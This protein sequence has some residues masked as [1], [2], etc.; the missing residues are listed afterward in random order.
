MLKEHTSGRGLEGSPHRRRHR[1]RASARGGENPDGAPVLHPS[2]R[3]ASTFSLGLLTLAIGYAVVT[4]GGDRP[5]DT[6]LVLLLVGL[7]GIVDSFS[8]AAGRPLSPGD[9]LIALAALL[10]PAYVAFQLVPLPIGFLRVAAP[11]RAEIASALGHV[12]AAPRFAPLSIGPPSTWFYLARVAGYTLTFL[13]VWRIARQSTDR[14]WAPAVP[15]IVIGALEA[16]G[17]FAQQSAMFGQQSDTAATFSGTYFNK[18]HFAGLLA[19]ILPFPLM[20]G[21]A[22]VTRGKRRGSDTPF[23]ALSGLLL[24]ALACAMFAA[25]NLSLSKAG[26]LSVLGSLFVIGALALGKRLS[27]WHRWSLLAGLALLV[28]F[29]FVFLTPTRLVEQFSVIVT[30]DATEG[31]LPIWKDTVRLIAAYPLFGVGMGNFYPGLLRYQTA[32]LSFTWTAAHNDYLQLL[33]ELGVVGW[34]IPAVL[35][36]IV[37]H[38][39]ARAALAGAIR[40][41]SLL[42]LACAGS[43]A[44]IVLHS[45]ADFNM[46]VL[47]NAMVLSWIAGLAAALPSGRHAERDG[48]I[49]ASSGAYTGIR[50]HTSTAEHAEHAESSNEPSFPASSAS[51]AVVLIQRRH[52]TGLR[53]ATRT[54]GCA[55][56]LLAGAWLVFLHGA[57][58]NPSLERLF[59][60]IGLCETV[61]T[62]V[63]QSEDGPPS[64]ATLA[65]LRERLERDPA[66]PSRWDDLGQALQKAGDIDAARYCFTRTLALGPNS[67]PVLLAAADFHFGVGETQTAL[68][69]MSR[70]LQ[71]DGKF[72]AA[73]FGDLDDR[74]I[75][76]DEILGGVSPDDRASRVYLRRLTTADRLAD[77]ET[78]WS[79]M[80]PRG[81]V[82]DRLARDYIDFLMSKGA[83]EAAAHAWARYAGRRSAGY[84]DANRIFNGDFEADPA[85]SRFD[86]TID[87]RQGTAIGF[88][89]DS[90]YSGARSLRIQFD[91]TGN[92]TDMS[93]Q[94]AVFLSPGAYRFRAYVRTKDVSTDQGVGFRLVRDEAPNQLDVTTE[95]IKGTN[96]WTLVERA[97]AAPPGGA[98]VR[99]SVVRRPS[100]KFDNLIRGTAWIDQVSIRPD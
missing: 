59:C 88:D 44:A 30:D 53:A 14:I 91:G 97:F 42:G 1:T 13:L 29:A 76:M 16:A 47:S 55:L 67:P 70:S 51:S 41:T 39:A 85:G 22:L 89:R 7:A 78:M 37:F 35:M 79:W 58:K 17:A 2:G 52:S 80:L 65:A 82:D 50:D 62:A 61:A 45:V 25:I 72:D 28:A 98:L 12:M 73:V 19:M 96:D 23:A 48:G 33:S 10:L 40:E 54:L 81:Y 84:P 31:R 57:V 74:R 93:I 75:G 100:L 38:R 43:I 87:P 86:W 60:R 49:P 4:Y 64:G 71:P 15:L 21:I 83:P 9:R 56:A 5:A 90:P 46:Y 8:R 92:V 69:L 24:L 95:D 34:L 11:T 6:Y 63:A 27:R 66:A 99:V 18:N 77:A 94:Q 32:G 20:Y 26:T 68:A 36:Y 3:P